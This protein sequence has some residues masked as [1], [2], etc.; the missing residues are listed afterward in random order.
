MNE[1]MQELVFWE[2]WDLVFASSNTPVVGCRW[3][4]T[5]K[6][7]QDGFMNIY[8]ARLIVKGLSRTYGIGYFETFSLVTRLRSICILL[9]LGVNL[10]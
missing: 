7:N 3:V 6:F 2:T 10:A 9:S 1:K 8:K 5:V 4:N